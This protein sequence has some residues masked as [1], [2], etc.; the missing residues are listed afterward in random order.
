MRTAF[1]DQ[2]DGLTALV[3]DMCGL[4][5]EAMARATHALLQADLVLA[6][7]VITDHDRLARMKVEAGNGIRTLGASVSGCR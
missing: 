7:H 1:H 2:L 5:G 4:A 3:G 6:E